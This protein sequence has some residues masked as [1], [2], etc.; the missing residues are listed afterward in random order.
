MD[1][2]VFISYVHDNEKE[3]QRLCEELTKCGVKVWLD[4][5]DIQPGIRW[6]QAIRR[7]IQNGAFFIACFSREYNERVETYMNKELIWAINRLQEFSNNRAWF[8]PIKLNECEIPDLDIG[9]GQTLE[10]LEYVEL[11]K[12]WNAG[13]KRIID[14]IKPI[15][16]E[17]QRLIAALQ[18]EDV[19][20]R[21]AA[22]EALLK[23]DIDN[24]ILPV[25]IEALK[26]ND[27][28][29]NMIEVLVK[30]G[31]PAVPVLIQ[32]LSNRNE[33]VRRSTAEALGKIRDSSTV[34]VLIQALSDN[35]GWVRRY[36]AEALVNIVDS[37]SSAIPE[38]IQA[39]SDKDN[40]VRKYFDNLLWRIG[41]PAVPALILA[42][43]DSDHLVRRRAVETLAHIGIRRD[44]STVPA[45]IKALS[46][47]DVVVRRYATEA[48]MSIGYIDSSA[49]TASIQ[50][51]NDNNVNASRYTIKILLNIYNPAV[52]ALIQAQ[53]DEDVMVRNNVALA[54]YS[55]AHSSI[56][57]ALIQSLNDKDE[58]VRIYAI[59]ELGRR[60]EDSSTI[61]AL[62]QALNDE[63]IEVHKYAIKALSNIDK[64]DIP[65]LI[66]FLSDR[67]KM[68][69][70]WTTRLLKN[71]GD[72]SAIPGL[73]QA[74]SDNDGWVRR[75]AVEALE[76]IATPNALK[77]VKEYRE[78][79]RGKR[80][81]QD[82]QS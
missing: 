6:E 45:F 31:K 63:S 59:E 5:N 34:Y 24:R 43:G 74:L 14:V 55:I 50:A 67:D 7:A 52:D 48:L 58:K 33:L 66:P 47:K 40:D 11:Y 26:Y 2:H 69:R 71:I 27:I 44:S 23:I 17:L 75:Y 28:C 56:V 46:D 42:L 77:A 60:I 20:I 29:I 70:R 68:V 10:A 65:M 80:T 72:S 32:L 4:R 22:S 79:W 57:P 53:S 78:K 8:I 15:T 82:K 1:N 18:S 25:L 35:D 41:S 13:V 9:I 30:I 61:A 64:S 54:L 12:D 21:K 36:A 3:V 76:Y 73:I 38:L 51:S 81:S 49:A 39:L 62:I 19:A 37:D 16:P